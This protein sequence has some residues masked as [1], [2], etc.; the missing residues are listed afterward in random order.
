MPASSHRNHT[1]APRQ[2]PARVGT[3]ASTPMLLLHLPGPRTPN[4]ALGAAPHAYGSCTRVLGTPAKRY[5]ACAP[6]RTCVHAPS[7]R[8]QKL[9][10][11]PC[12]HPCTLRGLAQSI[13]GVRTIFLAEENRHEPLSKRSAEAQTA[14]QSSAHLTSNCLKIG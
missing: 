3:R 4:I 8:Q 9:G 1:W 13:L 6:T 5:R 7:A 12:C 2:A 10:V 11:H 14:E